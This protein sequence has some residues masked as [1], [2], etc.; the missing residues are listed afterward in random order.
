[1]LSKIKRKEKLKDLTYTQLKIL[2]NKEHNILFSLR[3]R[4][5]PSKMNYKKMY[6]YDLK[7][8]FGCKSDKNQR[9]Q[10]HFLKNMLDYFESFP[11]F[12]FFC[13]RK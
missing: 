8:I 10:E 12:C 6:K 2:N 11:E 13:R 4:C 5:S 1:M 3:F 9:H 7:C